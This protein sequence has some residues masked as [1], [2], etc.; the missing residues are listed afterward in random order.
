M[1]YYIKRLIIS[2]NLLHQILIKSNDLHCGVVLT[3]LVLQLDVFLHSN[4]KD[5]IQSKIS[6]QLA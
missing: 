6:I 1:T 3:K 2:N 5:K 4:I